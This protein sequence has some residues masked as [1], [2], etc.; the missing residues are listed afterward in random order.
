MQIEMW[1][2]KEAKNTV[3][4]EPAP[5]NNVTVYGQLYLPKEEVGDAAVLVVDFQVKA[6]V[7]R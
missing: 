5:T 2:V 4:F 7:S 3:R 6:T 1:R